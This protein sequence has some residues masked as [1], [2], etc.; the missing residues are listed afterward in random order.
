[1]G[2][3]SLD[4]YIIYKSGVKIQFR[5]FGGT[6]L[7]G[8][9][10]EV[11]GASANQG[12]ISLGPINLLIKNHLGGAKQIPTTAARMVKNNPDQMI[13]DI[14]AGLRKFAK[15][16][17]SEIEKLFSDPKKVT[18]PFLYSKWQAVQLFNLIDSIKGEKKNQ[19]CEDFLLYASSQSSISAPYYKLE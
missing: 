16:T 3:E 6:K 4:G 11:K 13:A 7:T 12:K 5:T 15:S 9:Q 19:L 17:P 2:K 14:K 18:D 8:W 10:G 1:M